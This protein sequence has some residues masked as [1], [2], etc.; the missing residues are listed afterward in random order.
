MCLV[1]RVLFA[2]SRPK[3]SPGWSDPDAALCVCDPPFLLWSLHRLAEMSA[4]V[5]RS[6]GSSGGVGYRLLQIGA[7]C[8]AA[9]GQEL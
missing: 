9:T 2:L 5:D 3:G 4:S 1:L 7:R 8:E 6:Q